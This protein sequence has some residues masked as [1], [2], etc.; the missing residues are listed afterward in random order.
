MS[1]ETP[2]TAQ[3]PLFSEIQVKD[4][5]PVISAIIK[6]NLSAI[7]KLLAETTNLKFN[8]LILPLQSLDN[9]LSK[10][11]SPIR[12]LH[13]VKD[14]PELREAYNTI[15]PK[16]TDYQTQISLNQKL[17]QA[18]ETILN[19]PDFSALTLDQQQ[20]IKNTVRDFKLSG[21]ALPLDKQK[22]YGELRQKLSQLQTQFEQNVLDSTDNWHKDIS[23]QEA[24]TLL[25]GIPDRAKQEAAQRA[26]TVNTTGFRF[27]LDYPSYSAIITF[28]DNRELREIFYQAYNTKAS[29]VGPNAGKWD[30]SDILSNIIK[31]RQ[32]LAQL[33]GFKDYTQ[34]SLATKMVKNPNQVIDFLSDLALKVK[35]MAQQEYLA[36]QAYARKHYDI[37][38]I[39][40]WDIPYVSEKMREAEFNI[41][42]EQL[43]PYFPE[44]KVISGL[45]E[46]VQKLYPII[47]QERKDI[48]TWD[49]TVRFY[50]ILDNQTHV[51]IGQ[52]YFDLYA[53]PGKRSG[54]WMDECR[55]R[56]KTEQELQTPVAYLTCNFSGPI[57]NTPA[58][59]THQEV[60]TLF[61]EFGHGLHHMLTQIDYLAIS[62]ISGVAWDAVE[63]PSQFLENW[64]WQE[65]SINLISSHYETHEPLPKAMLTKLK[66]AKNFQSGL[67]TLRQLEFGLF[68]FKLHQITDPNLL[69]VQNILALNNQI[70]SDYGVI[71]VPEYHRFAHSFGHIFAGGYAAGYYSYMWAE[72]MACDAFARFEEEGIFNAQTGASFLTHIL[73]QG[74]SQDFDKLFLAF[75][76]RQPNQ[77][78]FLKNKGI[79]V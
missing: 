20:I 64:C 33:L 73:S 16:L 31:T 60:I 22:I 46:I 40:P 71:K 72:V 65:A 57:G 3:L 41:N 56:F 66:A 6:E 39:Q 12:H 5:D 53:R 1:I 7:A 75:R 15:L 37:N 45:F 32:E 13:A 79:Y 2:F 51:L 43:R 11:F 47:I 25:A 59:F 21:V 24:A 61:H 14:T 18:Y 17:Y 54:A 70:R 48:D 52:F 35:P 49:S 68:D 4:I 34:Y 30:N 23:E 74:G 36:I 42:Q 78:A 28:A 55:S 10:A 69:T 19:S 27:G 76:G 77:E 58:L 67:A 44:Q 29:D 38:E 8:D 9:K 50:D 63:V 26:K 62:G